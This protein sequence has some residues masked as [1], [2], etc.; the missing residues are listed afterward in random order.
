MESG[1][2]RSSPFDEAPA[3]PNHRPWQPLPI[4]TKPV[5]FVDGLVTMAG[6]G[7]ALTHSGVAVHIYAA[8]R[9]MTER[10]FFNADGEMLIVPQQ[11]R[12]LRRTGMGILEAAPGGNAGIQRGLKFRGEL[13]G[14]PA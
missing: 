8:N 1:L 3:P 12:L 4:P 14:A 6:N 7:D 10:F 9:S 13:L 11:G 2:L 5:D